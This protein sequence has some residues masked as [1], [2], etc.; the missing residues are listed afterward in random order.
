[1]KPNLLNLLKASINVIYAILVRTAEISVGSEQQKAS[2][3]DFARVLLQKIVLNVI[4]SYDEAKAFVLKD[5]ASDCISD[6]IISIIYSA[7][8]AIIF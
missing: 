8:N 4:S 7:I 3:L 6:P 2:L 5:M 1:M